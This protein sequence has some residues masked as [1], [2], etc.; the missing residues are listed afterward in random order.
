MAKASVHIPHPE[1]AEAINYITNYETKA[2]AFLGLIAMG[3]GT[4]R[5]LANEVAGHLALPAC[6]QAVEGFVRVFSDKGFATV[7][8][9]KNVKGRTARYYT[10]T[11][12]D[13]AL[14]PIGTLLEWSDRYDFPLITALSSSPSRGAGG[15]VNTLQIL[16]TLLQGNRLNETD[17]PGYKPYKGTS[18]AYN[19]RLDSLVKADLVRTDDGPDTFSILDPTYHG[20]RPFAS[21]SEEVHAIYA[22]LNKAKQIDPTAEWTA[23]QIINIALK[24]NLVSQDMLPK[25]RI[26]LGRAISE[27]VSDYF[28]DAIR[29]IDVRR[30][31]YFINPRYREMIEDL[32]SRVIKVDTSRRYASKMKELALATYRDRK[33]AKRI[34]QRGLENSPY[35][36]AL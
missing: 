15:P 20:K 7:E 30:R 24:D 18:T 29:K 17:L 23:E 25:F 27:K 36:R 33:K 32:V 12:E 4:K 28:P 19:T 8:Q 21:L 26:R 16:E 3:E 22:A 1:T 5:G 9:R 13:I 35:R 31:E 2:V 6:R 10:A 34:M 14:P 11:R